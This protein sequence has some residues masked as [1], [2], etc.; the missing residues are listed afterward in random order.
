VTF[1]V[2]RRR[3]PC[4]LVPRAFLAQ[5]EDHRDVPK[6]MRLPSCRTVHR[7]PR[8]RRVA[9]SVRQEQQD[10]L[11]AA[12]LPSDGKAAH[13]SVTAGVLVAGAAA[14]ADSG[15]VGVGTIAV[16]GVGGGC[17]PGEGRAGVGGA[18]GLCALA[19]TLWAGGAGLSPTAAVAGGG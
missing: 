4:G 3:C 15:G 7:D 19:P 18:A 5:L 11:R 16:R 10:G 2:A 8:N 12:Y 1:Y 6:S 13:S 17:G 9:R 14:G